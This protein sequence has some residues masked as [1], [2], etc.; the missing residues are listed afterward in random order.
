M[1]HG[2]KRRILLIEPDVVLANLL[3]QDF[4]QAGYEVVREAS[5]RAG[6]ESAL[7]VNVDLVL[8]DIP[9]PGIDGFVSVREI[10]RRKPQ[11]PVVIL[12]ALNKR[13]DVLYGF[14]SGAA[15]YVTKPFDLDVLRARIEASLRRA[16]RLT[17][18]SPSQNDG[19]LE[20]GNLSLDRKNHLLRTPAGEIRLNPK[21]NDLLSLLLSQPGHLFPRSAILEAVWHESRVSSSRSLDVHVRRVR[22]KLE[23]LGARVRIETVRGVGHRVVIST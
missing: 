9:L 2:R 22:A 15:D 14:A 11:V 21:E 8:I 10:V 5:G 12:T 17:V 4:G 19:I 3:A 16:S 23:T 1:Y 7:G 18:C 6:L 13:E 20:A